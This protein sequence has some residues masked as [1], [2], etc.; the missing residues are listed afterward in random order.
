[1]AD[2]ELPII[3][4]SEI[5]EYEFC[6]RAWWLRREHGWRSRYPERLAQGEQAH[7]AHGRAVAGSQRML[8]IGLALIGLALALAL[9]N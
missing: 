1:M 8:L 2:D 4:A 6:A 9:L 7:A 5:G 3:R